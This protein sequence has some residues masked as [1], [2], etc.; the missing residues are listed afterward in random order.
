LDIIVTNKHSVLP[1]IMT[2]GRAGVV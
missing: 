2:T 1:A